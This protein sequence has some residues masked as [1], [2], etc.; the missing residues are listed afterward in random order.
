M[1]QPDAEF[2]QGGGEVCFDG[3]FGDAEFFGDLFLGI[4]FIATELED[5]AAFFR[6]G[7]YEGEEFGL[8]F[9]G[10]EIV[11]RVVSG[12]LPL[13]E[14]LLFQL[15]VPAFDGE[16]FEDLIFYGCG[17]IGVEGV[18]DLQLLAA[19]PQVA[20]YILYDLAGF[21]EA[22][23]AV[24]GDGGQLIPIPEIDAGEG[25]FVTLRQQFQ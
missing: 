19:A 12:F 17:E 1:R 5:D 2:A 3:F 18:G 21:F 25:V 23:E 13:I 10:I 7:F 9:V 14:G 11:Q 4:A 24:H 8:Q 22:A 6:E 15:P 20:E 16:A